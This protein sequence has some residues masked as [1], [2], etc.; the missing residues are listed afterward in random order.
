MLILGRAHV[1]EVAQGS[2][3]TKGLLQNNLFVMPLQF[4]VMRDICP[5]HIAGQ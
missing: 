2:D 1:A 4:I 5:S 3:V